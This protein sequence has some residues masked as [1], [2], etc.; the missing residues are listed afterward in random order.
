[1]VWTPLRVALWLATGDR[2]PAAVWTAAQ[3]AT[4]LRKIRGHRLYPLFQLLILLGLRRGE[5][6]GL[7][8]SDIDLEGGYLAVSHQIRQVGATIEIG[9]PASDT[10]NR[11]IALD[12]GT[13]ALLRRHLDTHHGDPA[14]YMFLNVHGHPTGPTR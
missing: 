8:L 2:P 4:F 6:I 13:I 10:S 12:H 9:K 1:M 3:T 7:R 11:V 14:G 5:V